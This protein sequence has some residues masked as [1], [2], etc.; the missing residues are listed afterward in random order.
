M[1]K[2]CAAIAVPASALFVVVI[3]AVVGIIGVYNYT[4]PPTGSI[5]SSSSP[6]LSSSTLT[7]TIHAQPSSGGQLNQTGGSY[8]LVTTESSSTYTISYFPCS[9]PDARFPDVGQTIVNHTVVCMSGSPL[10]VSN[11]G[12][13]DF[14]NGSAVEL[15][16]NMTGSAMVSGLYGYDTVVVT[17]GTRFIFNASG[18]IATLY[19]YQGKEVS[20]TAR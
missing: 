6:S 2:R 11:D 20:P 5:P 13:V 9:S 14:M 18:V 19:P 4:E 12:R 17:N 3:I 16:A 15:H 7:T 1:M 8:Y 10:T